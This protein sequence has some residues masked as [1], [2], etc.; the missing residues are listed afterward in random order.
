MLSESKLKELKKK[1]LELRESTIREISAFGSGHIGGSM[2]IIELLTYLYFDEMNI[3]PANPKKQDRDR[4]VCS[5]GHAG[6][7]V[8]AALQ[9][10]GYFPAEWL[11]TLNQGG[12]KLP[13]HCDMTKTPGVDFTGG[14]LG[15]GISAAVGIALGQR[16]QK[17]DARTF[18]II[19]DGEAQEGQVYEA[20]ETA[21]AWKLD[22]LMIFLDNNGQQLDGYV[23]DIIPQHDLKARYA[24][25]GLEVFEIN[26][27][28]FNEIADVIEK[29]K[30]IRDKAVFVIMNTE[31]SHGYIPG[32][33]VKSNHS[34]QIS[35]E[36]C[37]KAIA[38]LRAR[39]EA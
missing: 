36:A 1:A 18:C 22:N 23:A 11:T 8:Y 37:E 29:A 25:F 10:K 5:K 32:E 38:D 26:G 15:Q 35:S 30:E 31:K 19:G 2:S 14:S 27:H 21:G 9:K 24:S 6:P 20:L 12:T 39:E 16:L 28:D 3:D 7:A 17:L 33:G 4:L 13:S 34:M